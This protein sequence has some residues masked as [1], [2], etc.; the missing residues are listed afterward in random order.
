MIM[1]EIPKV[2]Y[3]VI[4]GSGTWAAN[5]RKTP[6]LKASA[7]CSGIWSLKPPLAPLCP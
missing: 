1:K 7:S 6:A 5:I 4:G 3:A 2:R